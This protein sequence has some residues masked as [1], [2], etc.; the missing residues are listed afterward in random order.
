M[1]IRL[2]HE[3]GKLDAIEL[4]HLNNHLT[5]PH[6][7]KYLKSKGAWRCRSIKKIMIDHSNLDN[8]DYNALHDIFKLT[9]KIN[10][11][12]FCLSNSKRKANFIFH[13]I[14]NFT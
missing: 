14:I 12:S 11:I 4:M 8:Q 7:K 9:S 10:E 2:K 1:T 5:L 6:L 3:Q 13:T